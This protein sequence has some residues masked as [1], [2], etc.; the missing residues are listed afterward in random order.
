MLGKWC[1]K[2]IHFSRF[3]AVH[4]FHLRISKIMK[5]I[6]AYHS[7]QT[8]RASA[9]HTTRE[10]QPPLNIKMQI[11]EVGLFTFTLCN[12]RGTPNIC[13]KGRFF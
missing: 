10:Q 13:V 7:S 3:E 5:K 6:M 2:C 4:N 1:P 9:I 12:G 8:V 11:F